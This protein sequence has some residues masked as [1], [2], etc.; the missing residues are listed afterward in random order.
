M[1]HPVPVHQSHQVGLGCSILLMREFCSILY[2]LLSCLFRS[3]T[4]ACSRCCCCLS[5]AAARAAGACLPVSSVAPAATAIVAAAAAT[6]SRSGTCMSCCLVPLP[7]WFL[8]MPVPRSLPLR[9]PRA[10]GVTPWAYVAGSATRCAVADVVP[11]NA[12]CCRTLLSSMATAAS[13][14]APSR[15]TRSASAVARLAAG[16]SAFSTA[17]CY[18]DCSSVSSTDRTLLRKK[19]CFDSGVY[20]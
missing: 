8:P 1:A 11:F 18:C 6:A 12:A 4:P 14:S 19:V 7:V 17:G 13:S 10:A 20:L 3:R 15:S 9:L 2:V 5:Y 16:A